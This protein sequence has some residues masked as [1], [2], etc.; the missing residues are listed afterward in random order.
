MLTIG[1]WRIYI[2]HMRWQVVVVLAAIIFSIVV[3]PSLPLMAGGESMIGTLN[4]CHSAAP[5]LL[6]SGQMPCINAVPCTHNP[7]LYVAFC[8]STDLVFTQ[9]FLLKQNE[10]PPKA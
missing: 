4:I 3:P 7:A 6:S 9:L 5:A 8:K 10:H 2:A 1:E